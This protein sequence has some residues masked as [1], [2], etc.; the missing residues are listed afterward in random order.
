MAEVVLFNAG[1][2]VPFIPLME[3]VGSGDIFWPAQI[4]GILLNCALTDGI[5]LMVI[6]ATD[7]HTPAAGV[8][9]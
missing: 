2:Q 8:N 7:A 6:L 5:M 9:V 3:V 1:D 4:A